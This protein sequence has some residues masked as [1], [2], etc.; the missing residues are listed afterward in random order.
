[1]SIAASIAEFH[2]LLSPYRS[3][4]QGACETVPR[5]IA[6][7]KTRSLEEIRSAAAAGILDFG[8]NYVQEALPKISATQELSLSWHFIGRMQRNKVRDVAQ[9]FQWIHTVDRVEIAQ[10]L[11]RF[12]TGEPLN[13]CI[14][15]DIEATERRYGVRRHELIALLKEVETLPGLRLRGLMVMPAP[16]KSIENLRQAFRT[17]KETFDATASQLAHPEDWDTLSMGMSSDFELALREGSN[18]LRIGTA[19]FGPRGDAQ[20]QDVV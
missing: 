14:Q 6:V 4:S 9:N 16:G 1:M 3:A 2:G 15:L 20:S 13:V 18:C 17:A 11:S 5:L 12:C 8:E 19:I 7:S 10:R